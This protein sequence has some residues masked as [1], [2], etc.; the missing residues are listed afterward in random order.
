MNR[1]NQLDDIIAAIS[2][3]LGMGGIGIVRLSG[4][5][6]IELADHLFVGNK[7]LLEKKSHTLSYGKIICQGEVIDEALVSVM[8]APQTYTKEDIVEINCHGGALITRK[9]LEVVLNEG[10]RLAEPGEF[11][12]RAFLNGRMDLTQAEAVIDIIHSRTDLSR[13]A[14]VNQ[15]E[16]R[17]KTEV[18]SMREE[19]SR[20]DCRHRGSN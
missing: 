8:K 9:I 20:Y 2:T 12:K 7:S 14:A 3:P 11:T 16:G 4:Q 18:R 19:N 13:Q 17:L 15:L 5:G 10:A 1:F 6:C